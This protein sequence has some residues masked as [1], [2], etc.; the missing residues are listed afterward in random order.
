MK[1]VEV[2]ESQPMDSTG[3]SIE[4]KELPFFIG[5]KVHVCWAHPGAHWTLVRLEGTLAVLHRNVPT[6]PRVVR[7]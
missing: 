7:S 2:K 3:D 4:D 6:P 1:L 5:K